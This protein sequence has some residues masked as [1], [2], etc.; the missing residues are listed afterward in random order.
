[1]RW[2]LIRYVSAETLWDPQFA[3]KTITGGQLLKRTD[4]EIRTFDK[5]Q[6]V[7]TYLQQHAP[8]DSVEWEG[9]TY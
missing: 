6:H 7:F 4:G 5:V 8:Q 9:T 1:M 2:I 3:L